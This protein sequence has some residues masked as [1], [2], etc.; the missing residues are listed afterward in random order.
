MEQQMAELIKAMQTIQEQN[1]SI[2]GLVVASTIAIEEMAPVVRELAGW[3]PLVEGAVDELKGEVDDLKAQV[4]C[5]TRHP[6]L[7]VRPTDLQGLLPTPVKR[8]FS[9]GGLPVV[10]MVEEALPRP[11]GHHLSTADRGEI[12]RG[13]SPTDQTSDKENEGVEEEM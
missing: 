7:K 5:I 13:F 6:V 10:F 11:A 9:D 8:S 12:G 1:V 4:D 3:R 2:Q